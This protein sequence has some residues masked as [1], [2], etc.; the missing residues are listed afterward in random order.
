[1]TGAENGEQKGK[2]LHGVIISNFAEEQQTKLPKS[3]K[4]KSNWNAFAKKSNFAFGALQFKNRPCH[5]S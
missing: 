5:S 2:D 1:M 4:N 3:D